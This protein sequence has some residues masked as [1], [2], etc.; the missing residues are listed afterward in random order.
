MSAAARP[1]AR[2]LLHCWFHRLSEGD[3]FGGGP[4]VDALLR[5]RFGRW[6]VPLGGQGATSFLGDPATARAAILLFDQVPRN[7]HR[8]SALAYRWDPLARAITH[9]FVARGWL[10]RLAPVVAQFVLMPLMHSEDIADQRASLA[11]FARHA[12]GAFAFAR[13]HHVMVARFGRFPHRNA[14]LG[15]HSTPAEERALAAGFSW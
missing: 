10:H 9:G 14:L 12:R 3:W 5:R 2:D 11:L 7:L 15:R 6:I 4:D 8:D 13:S 1:W